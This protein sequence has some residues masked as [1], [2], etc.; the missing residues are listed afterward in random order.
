MLA[1]GPI[2]WKLKKQPSV[3]LSTTEVEYYALGITCQE[4]AWIRHVYQEIFKPLNNPVLVYS[5]NA[6]AVALSVN[7]I[8]H[9][10]S[11]H[12]DIHWHYIRDL[13]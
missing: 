9:N 4:A 11:K 2:S 6:G 7:P 3:S 10:R 13:I 5:D 1:G 8:F 12:I